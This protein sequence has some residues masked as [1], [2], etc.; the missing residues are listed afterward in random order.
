MH[1]PAHGS[2]TVQALHSKPQGL[3]KKE[4]KELTHKRCPCSI[5]H[6]YFDLFIFHIISRKTG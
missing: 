1:I 2:S 5:Y 3:D 6:Y 4:Q